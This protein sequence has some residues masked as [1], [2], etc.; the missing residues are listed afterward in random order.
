MVILASHALASVLVLDRIVHLT[1]P[2]DKFLQLLGLGIF[3]VLI[4]D[5]VLFNFHLGLFNEFKGPSSNKIQISSGRVRQSFKEFL[6]F[7]STVTY[8]W[9]LFCINWA[10]L[11][12]IACICPGL[13]L[14]TCT[15]DGK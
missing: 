15:F 7:C 13:K 3:L 12:C 5:L 14:E 2:L 1:I 4:G 9:L 8:A 6:K 11:C 10:C